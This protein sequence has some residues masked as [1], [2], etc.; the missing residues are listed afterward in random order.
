MPLETLLDQ[1]LG[2]LTRIKV[3]RL[4][5]LLTTELELP[6]AAGWPW[7]ER[8]NG[9]I[10]PQPHERRLHRHAGREALSRCA[11]CGTNQHISR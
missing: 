4:A 9:W 1:L 11:A 10:W 2:H 5:A 3:V 6:C 8:V 7:A